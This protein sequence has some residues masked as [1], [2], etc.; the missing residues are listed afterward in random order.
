MDRT[1]GTPK[2][3]RTIRLRDGRQLAYAEWADLAGRP[4]VLLHGTPGSRLICLDEDATVAAGVRLITVDRPGYG[5][6]NP[7][8]G[9]TVL[10]WVD[11]FI[12]FAEKLELPP[13][14]VIGWSGGGPYAL[15]LGFRL[16]DRITGIGLAAA[17]GPIDPVPGMLEASVPEG[18]RAAFRLLR[19]D[20]AAGVAAIEDGDAWFSGDGWERTFARSWGDADDRVLAD[21]ATLEAMK[22]L[23][24]EAARQG[25]AGYVADHIAETL[26]WSFSLSEITQP[27]HI[28][29]GE[30]DEPWVPMSADYLVANIPDVTLVTYPGE[31]HLFP[32]DHWAEMLA[33]M[34]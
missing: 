17:R 18:A 9:R 22:T 31:A 4:V 16:P 19:Q 27:V 24:R 33:A 1:T 20:Y 32:F 5:L 28:W 11:D 14:P 15:A 8:A 34:I 6:S 12:E 23:I 13:C 25:P 30:S 10:G 29:Y 21:P 7:R 3:D 26:P 2:A